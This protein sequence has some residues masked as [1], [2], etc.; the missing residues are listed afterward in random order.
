MDQ[1]QTVAQVGEIPDGEGRA[2]S[3]DGTVVAVFNVGGEYTAINDVCPHMGASLAEGYVEGVSVTCPWHAWR[4]SV[5]DGT[6]LDNPRSK[7]ANACYCVRVVGD[8]IQVA[9]G[10]TSEPPSTPAQ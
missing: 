8:E 10:S 5:K 6:W 9:I 4:F 3:V 2:F 1:F 7:I